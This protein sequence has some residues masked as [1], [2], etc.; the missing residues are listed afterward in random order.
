MSNRKIPLQPSD[1]HV[2]ATQLA[3]QAN[4]PTPSTKSLHSSKMAFDRTNFAGLRICVPAASPCS[5]PSLFFA[6]AE[7]KLAVKGVQANA[8]DEVYKA[9]MPVVRGIKQ[10]LQ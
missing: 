1:T 3:L 6:V 10:H 9:S 7:G 4:G 5:I 8:G 2:Q